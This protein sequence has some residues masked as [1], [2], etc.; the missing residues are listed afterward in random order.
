MKLNGV[1]ERELVGDGWGRMERRSQ[2]EGQQLP[3]Q[4]G[5][6]DSKWFL[7]RS[8]DCSVQMGIVAYSF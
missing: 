1:G 3:R 6:Q 7:E 4:V 2:K 8:Q 5:Q